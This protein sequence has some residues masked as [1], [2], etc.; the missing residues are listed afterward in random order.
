MD[1]MAI[2][3]ALKL[4]KIQARMNTQNNIV[5]VVTHPAFSIVTCFLIIETAQKYGYMGENVGTILEG[6][7]LAGGMLNAIGQ[8]GLIESVT[9]ALP[10]IGALA[11]LLAAGA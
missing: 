1:R 8:S 5:K 10:A 2:S 4:A 9:K 3:E 6:G 11:P 7:L